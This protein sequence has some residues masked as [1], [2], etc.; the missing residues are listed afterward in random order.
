MQ[1][2]SEMTQLMNRFLTDVGIESRVADAVD[3]LAIIVIILLI[4]VLAGWICR[5]LLVHVVRRMVMKWTNFQWKA[6]L[7]N[8]VILRKLA[9]ILP[10]ILIYI[11]I[12]LAFPPGAKTLLLLQKLCLVYI[13][14]VSV[15]FI[16]LCFRVTFEVFNGKEEFR[17]RPLKGGLQIV[18]VGLFFLGLVVIVSILFGKSPMKLLTGLGASAAILMLVFK[19]SIMGFVSGIMLS[20]N[21]M[22]KPGDWI[23]MPKYGL[24]GTVVEVTLNTVKIQGFD[25]T[26]YMVP[27]YVLTSDAFQNWQAMADSGGRRVMRSV[28]I[29]MNSVKFCTPEMLEKYKKIDL[30]RDYIEKK[31]TEQDANTPEHPAGADPANGYALTNIGLLREYLNRYVAN[32]PVLNKDLTYMVRHLQP[33]E[34]GIPIQLYFFSSNKE[35]VAY[36]GIQADVFD[37]VMAIVPQFDLYIFQYPSGVDVQNLRPPVKES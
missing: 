10:V 13:I 27:P 37:H 11:L 9:D 1:V 35:W 32:L 31:Q 20:Y 7:L 30:I 17:D 5:L 36:E 2:K 12:P 34:T 33:T 26:M 23:N 6:M 3:Q 29:D 28:S 4:A 21:H 22:L 14:I 24:E 18:Q 8:P 25:N 16:D 19:D 15:L